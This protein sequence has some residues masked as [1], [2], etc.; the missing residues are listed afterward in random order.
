[1]TLAMPDTQQRVGVGGA[2]EAMI[3]VLDAR[4][5]GPDFDDRCDGCGDCAAICPVGVIVMGSDGL[6]GL[7]AGAS[8]CTGCG[9]CEDVCTRG[10]LSPE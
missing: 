10:A 8:P 7:S 6:P 9:L 5:Y 3:G 1:M 2:G 4:F